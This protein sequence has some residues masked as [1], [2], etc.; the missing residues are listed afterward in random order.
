MENEEQL[1]KL[2][3]LKD[4]LSKPSLLLGMHQLEPFVSVAENGTPMLTFQFGK[5]LVEILVSHYYNKKHSKECDGYI[6]ELTSNGVDYNTYEAANVGEII[7]GLIP[8][9]EENFKE[10]VEEDLT[11]E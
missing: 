6:V 10:N 7:N 2:Q 9:N 1:I 5:Y 3:L 11:T 4:I 8:F